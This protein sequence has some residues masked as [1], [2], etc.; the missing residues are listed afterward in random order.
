VVFTQ[1]PKQIIGKKLKEEQNGLSGFVALQHW[2][3]EQFGK[4]LTAKGVKPICTFQQVFQSTY[5]F[6]AFSPITA[7]HFTLE[8]PHCDS[9][10][11]QVFLDQFSHQKRKEFKIIVL[12]NG[13]FHKAKALN[14]PPNIALVF[15][16]PYSAALNPAEKIWWLLKQQLVCKNFDNILHLSKYLS[17]IIRKKL[18]TKVIKTIC[19]FQYLL[20]IF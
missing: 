6:G 3:E 18:H 8:L 4:A 5:V 13:A 2:I 11:F 7:D 16:P 12:D 14:M 15:L 1:A 20:G 17:T 10:I 19:S 9:S